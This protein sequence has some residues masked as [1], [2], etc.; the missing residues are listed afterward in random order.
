MNE[1]FLFYY[2]N[3][4]TFLGWVLLYQYK[5]RDVAIEELQKIHR[6]FPDVIPSTDT[7]SE[8]FWRG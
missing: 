5:F 2:I 4:L 3:P 6:I 8:L 1:L 7:Y